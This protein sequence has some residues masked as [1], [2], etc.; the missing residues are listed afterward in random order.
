[1]LRN[2]RGGL[3]LSSEAWRYLA[4][5][6]SISITAMY[7]EMVVLPS[8]PTIERQFGITESEASWVL[9]SETL[10]GLAFAPILGKLA[11]NYGRK[12]VLLATLMVY[13]VA[14]FL[15]SMAPT[16]PILIMLRAIQGIGL[17][18][19]PI[20]Y[21][22]LRERLDPKEWPVTKRLTSLAPFSS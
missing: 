6:A 11:D 2:V 7:V 5:L 21:T 8:L 18:I 12:R 10:A 9:S 4:V 13:F 19:N 14:V 3:R 1:V 15:T 17:S 16:Y 22:L 20:G